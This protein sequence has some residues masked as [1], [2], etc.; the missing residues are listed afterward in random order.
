MS[1]PPLTT[2]DL[3]LAAWDSALA[4]C[5]GGWQREHRWVGGW[6]SALI[7]AYQNLAVGD[8][9]LTACRCDCVLFE[10]WARRRWVGGRVST[11]LRA[12]P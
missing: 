4:T 3:N 11:A 9:A 6:V 7:T 12:C 1:L 8:G 10:A 2:A 5:S